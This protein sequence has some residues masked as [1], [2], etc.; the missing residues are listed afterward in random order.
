MVGVINP[1]QD[2][3]LAVQKEFAA[4]STLQLVPGEP[5]PSETLKTTSTPTPTATP[6]NDGQTGGSTTDPTK[7][8][9]SSGLGA[10][11]IAGIAIGAA[12]VLV[13]G[14]GVI[15]LCGRRGGFERAYHKGLQPGGP[16]G[17]HSGMPPMAAAGMYHDPKS[18]GQHTVSTFPGSEHDYR[19]SAQ[20]QPPLGGH[21][22][23][24]PPPP[25]SP[26]L[27]G[28]G[29]YQPSVAHNQQYDNASQHGYYAGVASPQAF[30]SPQ[31]FQPPPSEL[32]ASA[33]HPA[34]GHSP[35][36]QYPVERRDSYNTGGAVTPSKFK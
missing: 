19:F 29:A 17:P 2:M 24:T 7:D 36:P 6:N 18:P 33:E 21:F 16:G 4:N 9:A 20:T 30:P 1:T 23:G 28:F 15:Y 35:P 12:A 25:N 5:F 34:Q 11:A 10:G 27:N 31:H 32:P 13:I 8:S 14:A 26:G 3:T 22:T